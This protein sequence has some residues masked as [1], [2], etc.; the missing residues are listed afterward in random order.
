MKYN[1][2][3]MV[4]HQ[5]YRKMAGATTLYIVLTNETKKRKTQ[6]IC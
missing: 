4:F 5:P 3:N 6:F 2:L 1:F